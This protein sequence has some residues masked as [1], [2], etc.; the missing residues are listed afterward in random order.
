MNRNRISKMFRL[1]ST[2]NSGGGAGGGGVVTVAL[3]NEN[4]RGISEQHRFTFELYDDTKASFHCASY[5]LP[6]MLNL[7][8]VDIRI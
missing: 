8:A 3:K 5:S 4:L 2:K 6:H 7:P 1:W